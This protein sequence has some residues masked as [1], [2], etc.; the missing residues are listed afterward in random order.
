MSRADATLALS[1][2]NVGFV[3]GLTWLPSDLLGELAVHAGLAA[4]GETL[5]ATAASLRVDLAFVDGGGGF[6]KDAVATLHA[7]DIAA[8]WCVDGVFGRVAADVGWAEALRMTAAEPGALAARLD[9]ALHEALVTVRAA[10]DASAD[11]VLVADDLAGPI[12]PLLSPDFALD[13][14]VPCYHRLAL[15]SAASGLPALFHSDGEIRAL[16]PA[17]ARAGFSAVHLAGL[18]RDGFAAAAGSARRAGLV[19]LGGVAASALPEGARAAGERAASVAAALGG[20]IVCDDGG[21][22]TFTQLTSFSAA[23]DAARDAY[24]QARS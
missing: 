24:R 8:I 20:V 23:L 12:G 19:V 18:D 11:A 1:G 10:F 15:E 13:A 17:L 22:M 3:S 6:A 5:G 16:M 21:L 7:A 2:A 14:L 4:D 9:E